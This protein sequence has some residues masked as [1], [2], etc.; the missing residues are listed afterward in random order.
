[1]TQEKPD[2]ARDRLLGMDQPI[3]RRDFLNG[4]AIGATAAVSGPLF[5]APLPDLSA[6]GASPGPLPGGAQLPPAAQDAAGYYPPLL[7]GMRGSH[8]G[9]FEGAHALRDGKTWPAATDTGEEYDLIVVGGGISGLAAAHFYRAHSRADSRILI[10]DNHDDFGGHAKRNEFNLDGHLNLL[11]G[12]TLEIDS[13]RPYGPIAAG[14]MK[15]LGIDVPK[16]AKT[17]QDLDY[18]EHLGLQS[19]VFFDRETFGADR[20]AV[21][22]GR[23]PFKQFLAQAPLS[24][25]ARDTIVQIQ[26]GKVDY[27]PGLSSDDKKQRLSRLSYEAFLRDLVHAEPA[28]LHYYHARTMGEWGVGADA[29]SALDCWG[30]G[31][32]GFQGMGLAKGSIARMGFTPAGYEDTGGSYRLHFPDGNATIARLLVRDLIPGA[33]PGNS[34]EDVITAR[35]NYA[36][37]DHSGAPIR[38]RLNSIAIRVRHLGDPKSAGRVE[39]TYLRGGRPFTARARGAVLACYNMMIPYLCPE[40]P[41][42]QKEALHRLIK[43]PLVYTSVAVRNRQAFDALKVHRVYAPGGYH[44]YFHLNPHVDIGAYRSPAS[45]DEPILVHMVRTPC[46]PGLPEHEQNRAGRA[47]LL[48]TSFETFE[49]NIREQLART[50]GKGGFDPA[51]DITAITVNRWPH[52]YAPEYNP[53]FDPDVPEAERPYVIG[54]AQFGRIAIANSDSGGGAYTD[55]A[56]DQGHRAVMELLHS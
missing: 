23:I 9:S 1:M 32:P 51:R 22:L 41:A 34:A 55:S 39:V 17:T 15:T 37:L 47:E 4:I 20:L 31:L 48:V 5:A 14:L 46:K 10:L 56:I 29:V 28:V 45:V 16:L 27:L 12:G 24:A 44:T 18:Y 19:A 7:T 49:R 11:N 50:L 30:F 38:L 13:P 54:R 35:V 33:V 26:E 25:S 53:L 40:L 43:T 8:P 36:Q 3:T 42:A 21:G 6:P 2:P 52:G